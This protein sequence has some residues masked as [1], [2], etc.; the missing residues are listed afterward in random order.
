MSRAPSYGA[1]D[2]CPHTPKIDVERLEDLNGNAFALPNDG[3]EDVLG[4]NRA[5]VKP[6]RLLLGEDDDA[7][8]ALGE[9]FK[10]FVGSLLSA[11]YLYHGQVAAVSSSSN[12]PCPILSP[13]APRTSR[14]SE[15]QGIRVSIDGDSSPHVQTA[16]H[17]RT[18]QARSRQ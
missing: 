12:R 6:F 2:F 15:D 18:L 7:A 13:G 8:G 4:A 11:G 17:A 9:P 5:M 3:E 14:G 1:L 10:H 16:L